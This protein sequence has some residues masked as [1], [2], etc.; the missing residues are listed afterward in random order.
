ML[1]RSGVAARLRAIGV[2]TV[3]VAGAGGTS[4]VAVEAERA[5]PGSPAARLGRELWDWGVPTAVS[6]VA[7]ASAGLTVIAS[8]GL[9]SGFD[10][11][12]AI[13]LGATVGGMAAPVLRAQRAGGEAA[14]IACVQEVLDALRSVCLLTG[15]RTPAA[16]RQAPRHLGPALAAYLRDLG[17]PTAPPQLP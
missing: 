12:R 14:A 10:V 9:R 8:G 3:D 15:C 6:T 11:A 5:Q 2:Q 13:V 4:W 16:L 17:L 1:F 7:C